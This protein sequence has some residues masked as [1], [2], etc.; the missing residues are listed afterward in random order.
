MASLRGADLRAAN[1]RG[2]ELRGTDFTKALYNQQTIFG[3]PAIIIK[4]TM[5]ETP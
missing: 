1:L 2:A 5:I 3:R 4:S